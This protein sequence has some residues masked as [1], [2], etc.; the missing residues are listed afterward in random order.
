MQLHEA[1]NHR[2]ADAQPALAAI[3]PA[4]ALR[5][6]LEDVRQELRLDA[7]SVVA[8]ANA[9]AAAVDGDVRARCCRRRTCTWR[10]CA[11]RC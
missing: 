10:R 11:A 5:E 7:D 8:H 1:P 4:V 2:E 9:D 6:H 3:E